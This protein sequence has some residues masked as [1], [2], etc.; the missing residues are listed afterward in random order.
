MTSRLYINGKFTAQRTTGVQRV[1][2]HLVRALDAI[3]GAEAF[4]LLLPPQGRPLGLRRIDER[5][6]G[7][8][9]WPLHAWEQLVLP[10][11]ARRGLL[12][13]L[14]GAAPAFAARQACM[15]HDAAVFDA[16]QAYTRLF[17]IWYRWLFRRLATRAERLFTVSEFSKQRLA[18]AL[19]LPAEAFVVLPNGVDHID[20][21]VMDPADLVAG[22]ARWDLA[23]AGYLLAVASHNPNKNL[24]RLV[25]AHG[26]LPE[27]R[28]RLVLVGGRDD[29]VFREVSAGQARAVTSLGAVGDAELRLLY[30]GALAL[31]FPSLYEGFGLPPIEAMACGCPVIASDAAAMPEVCGDAALYVDPTDTAGLAAAIRQLVDDAGLRGRLIA[32]GHAQSAAYRWCD[33]AHRLRQSLIPAGATS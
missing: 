6:V 14:A 7:R 20:A 21:R 5:V 9:R 13:N 31:V 17:A 2:E 22:L 10:F 32:A 26:M 1:A 30:A 16:P 12:L 33:S 8:H 27:P 23:P 15:F 18:R 19:N 28:C 3:D 24:A 29:A 4:T 11:V 25:E